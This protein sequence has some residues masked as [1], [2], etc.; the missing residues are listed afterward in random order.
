[1]SSSPIR[2]V[3]TL[4]VLALLTGCGIRKDL[5][6][7]ALDTIAESQ[8]R[9]GALAAELAECRAHQ[10]TLVATV[11][12]CKGELT[13]LAIARDQVLADNTALRRKLSELGENVDV[14]LEQK[15]DMADML[16][17]AQRALR[18]ARARQ[19]AAE[20]RDAIFRQIREKLQAMIDGGKLNVRIV[21]GR[22]VIDL[23]Q[24]IL[25]PSGSANLSELGVETLKEV[26]A[27]LIE[28]PKRSF[29]GRR[30]H[31]QRA[32]QDRPVPVQLGAIHG[33]RGVRSQ[34]VQ[35]RGPLQGSNLSAAGYGEFQPRAANESD[36]G[37]TLNRRI[38][39]VMVP[40]LQTL[41]DLVDTIDR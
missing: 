7:A 22:L 30:P 17:E 15:S 31:R 38:E 13:A 10:D 4:L 18:E 39:V 9:L 40:D 37:R 1:M 21:R 19:A 3:S 26:A 24:D 33:P 28:F 25:F 23:K 5:H 36:E 8:D 27:A 20:A 2:L 29:P 12:A 35:G 32:D 41:P 14:L 11:E 34:A 16:A 6:Q